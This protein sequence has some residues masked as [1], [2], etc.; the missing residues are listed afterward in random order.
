MNLNV[1]TR[2]IVDAGLNSKQ[3]YEYGIKARRII[4]ESRVYAL[5][6]ILGNKYNIETFWYVD[7]DT[8]KE[9]VCL[10]ITRN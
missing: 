5:K 2:D 10:S 3:R 6:S 9:N 8:T 1:D 7:T 4:D